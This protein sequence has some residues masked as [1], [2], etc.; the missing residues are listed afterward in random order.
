MSK[1]KQSP[2][3]P[4]DQRRRQLL[5]A[6]HRLFSDKGYRETSTEEI[7]RKAG[8][9]KGAVYFH[10]KNKEEI[11][12][13]IIRMISGTYR[14]VVGAAKPPELTPGR[15][16]MTIMDGCTYGDPREFR[17]IL[18]IWVQALRVPRIRRYINESHRDRIRE[19]CQQIKPV[20]GWSRREQ[21]Q[22]AVMTFALADGL[23]AHRVLDAKMVDSRIQAKM[24]QSLYDSTCGRTKGGKR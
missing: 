7:A 9:T 8:L 6:A 14:D 19:F 20:P 1:I 16:L 10:F 24:F 5:K 12:F 4:A 3:L 22:Y 11:L 2:K 13:E 15:M 18:D 17:S 23:A 21:E